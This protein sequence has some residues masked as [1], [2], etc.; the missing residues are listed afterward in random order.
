LSQPDYER[1]GKL[2][3]GACRYGADKTDFVHWMADGLGIACPDAD[4]VLATGSLYTAFAAKYT[5]DDEFQE[6]CERFFEKLKS[7]ST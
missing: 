6:N 1:I 2:I 4:N 5:N 7:R 3:Y